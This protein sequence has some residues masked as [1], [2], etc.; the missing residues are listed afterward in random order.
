MSELSNNS[1]NENANKNS[2][3]SKHSSDDHISEWSELISR[4][5]SIK[6]SESFL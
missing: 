2:D 5:K 1:G 4:Y 3:Q 6:L